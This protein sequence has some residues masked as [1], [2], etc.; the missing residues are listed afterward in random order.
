[1]TIE[2]AGQAALGTKSQ[3]FVSHSIILHLRMLGVGSYFESHEILEI[4]SSCLLKICEN[5]LRRT[6]QS[7]VDV[8]GCARAFQP[9]LEYEPT[10]Q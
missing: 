8:L 4:E 7:Q 3:A 2:L 6:D 9:Q 1:L 5:A 10:F